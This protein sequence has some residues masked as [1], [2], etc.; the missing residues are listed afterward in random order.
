MKRKQNYKS[1][2]HYIDNKICEWIP[3]HCIQRISR[4]VREYSDPII[5]RN[6]TKLKLNRNEL[7][8]YMKKY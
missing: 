6:S 8:H 2:E 3:N 1:N 5:L 7:Y 4:F